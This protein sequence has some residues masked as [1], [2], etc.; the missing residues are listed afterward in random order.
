MRSSILE[1]ELQPD[2]RRPARAQYDVPRVKLIVVIPVGEIVHVDLKVDM[3]IQRMLGHRVEYPIPRNFLDQS[4]GGI[5][6]HGGT[7]GT[8]GNIVP[9]RA[10]FPSSR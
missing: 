4:R 6:R 9:S 2:Q 8:A 1:F 7:G 10:G 3:L 5:E